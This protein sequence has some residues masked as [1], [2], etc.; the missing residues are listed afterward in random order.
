MPE[1]PD[2][3]LY[4]E[5]LQRRIVGKPLK[6]VSI[7]SPFLV[8]SVAPDVFSAEGCCVDDVFRIG[9]RIVWKFEGDLYL[10]FH[11]M[12]AGRFHLKTRDY[13]PRGK[14]DVAVFGFDDFALALTEASP[15]KRASLH[16]V[17]G[18]EDLNEFR[19][20]GLEVFEATL[21]QFKSA[22]TQS[23]RTLKRALTT[24]AAFSG[25]G[26]AYSDEILHAARLSP[27]KRTGQL[28]DEEI[29]RLYAACQ[30]TLHHWT[31]K[32]RREAG[33][34]FPERV[35]AFRDEMAV[36]GKFGQPC[37]DCDT[38]I[39]R[40]RYAENEVNYCPRCQ[41]GGKMLADRSLSRL[42]HDDWPKTIEEWEDPS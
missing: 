41:T 30:E 15:K 3:T 34:N 22:L 20:G 36:H 32:L 24:P 12:I 23:N 17:E 31:D 21:D 1:L 7:R 33:D 14:N 19:R 25:I 27:L 37:P 6:R 2:V 13:R 8:R 40:I 42:L 16:A 38:S 26:N 9:K 11:L 10:V 28:S 4:V 35:T 5:A 18:E 29:Q 39:Q